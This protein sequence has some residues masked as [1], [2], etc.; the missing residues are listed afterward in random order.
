M[1]L[2]FCEV[3]CSDALLTG[4]HAPGEL[5]VVLSVQSSTI[6]P[7]HDDEIMPMGTEDPSD[8][9]KYSVSSCA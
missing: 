4:L 2:R 6:V 5:N 9:S 8:D 7:P 3:F 1:S